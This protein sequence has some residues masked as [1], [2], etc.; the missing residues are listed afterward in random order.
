MDLAATASA[1]QGLL[2]GAYPQIKQAH[3]V[4]V[5]CSGALFAARGAGVVWLGARW[6]TA[7]WA[8]GLSVGIDTLLLAAGVMLWTLLGLHPVRDPWLGVK[9]L[10]LLAYIVVGSLAL[11]R[12]RTARRR[13]LAFV[14]ALG[15]YAFMASVALA[16]RPLGLLA[17]ALCV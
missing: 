14:A 9:L 3:I 1:L 7:A 13:R 2:G 16:H 12:G 15:L 11:K 8:R 17:W 5:G 10:L 4:L 6:P